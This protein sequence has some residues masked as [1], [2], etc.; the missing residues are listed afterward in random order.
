M[1]CCVLAGQFVLGRDY[2]KALKIQHLIKEEHARVLQE[3]AHTYEE[4]SP[5]RGRRPTLNP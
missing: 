4:V 5:H 1:L 2:S 3:M